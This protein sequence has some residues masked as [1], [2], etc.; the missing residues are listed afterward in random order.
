MRPIG[1]IIAMFIGLAI[2]GMMATW[3]F[4]GLLTL[5]G[6]IGLIE[7]IAILKWIVYRTSG[8]LDILIFIAGIMA[9]IKLGVTITAS[10]TVA[11]LGFTFL[12]RPWIQK[13]VAKRKASQTKFKH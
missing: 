11:G 1:F 6:L 5:A 2:G 13:Q 7:N 4:F 10:L 9:T 8:A 12:Y 3:I